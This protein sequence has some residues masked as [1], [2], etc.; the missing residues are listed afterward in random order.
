MENTKPERPNTLAGLIEKRAQ[1]A[2][3][4]KHHRAEIRK[5]TC[6]LDHIDA[7]IRL[8]D[9][10]AD[11]SRIIRY[12]TKH[13]AQKGE[14]S[15][16]VLQT[17]RKASEPLTS[18]DLVKLQARE[19]GLKADDQTIVVMRK[20]VGATLSALKRKGVVRAIPTDGPYKGWEL[21]R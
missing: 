14:A 17:L 21:A 12:P 20:R 8:F 7:A 16:F 1:L 13:R 19:R 15:R 10:N 4:L 18:L 2:G 9:P 5:V 11:V 3:M 6:D